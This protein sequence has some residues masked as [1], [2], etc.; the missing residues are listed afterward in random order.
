MGRGGDQIPFLDK[1]YPAVRF[2]V[3][4]EDYEH[5]HQYLRVEDGV[6][7]GDTPDEMDFAYLAKVT[8]LNVRALDALAGA[9]MPPAPRMEAAVSAST[10]HSWDEVAGADGYLVW[11]RRTDQ[12]YW[13][14]GPMARVA[15]DQP[16]M[17]LELPGVRGDDCI[18]GISA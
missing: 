9:P 15:A 2:S 1:G 5:Q 7:Y 14:E 8:Q 10:T 4:V 6:T 17:K 16:N 13:S 12:P 11:H 18:F 3:A